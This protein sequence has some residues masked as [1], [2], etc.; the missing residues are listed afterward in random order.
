M[1]TDNGNGMKVVGAVIFFSISLFMVGLLAA[2]LK[3]TYSSSP[4]SAA[5]Y[6]ASTR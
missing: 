1:T 6:P 4:W 5:S 3:D 2:Y